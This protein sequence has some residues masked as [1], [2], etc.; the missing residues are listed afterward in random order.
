MPHCATSLKDKNC[1]SKK[2]IVLFAEKQLTLEN[3][4]IYDH[5]TTGLIKKK[6]INIIPADTCAMPLP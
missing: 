3:H 6:E 2:R 1:H 5:Y 4:G